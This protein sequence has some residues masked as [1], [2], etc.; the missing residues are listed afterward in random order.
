MKKY[1]A[2]GNFILRSPL[3]SREEG[4]YWESIKSDD[5]FLRKLWDDRAIIES[6]AIDSLNL[7][8]AVSNYIKTGKGSVTAIANSCRKLI[9]R[10]S[11]RTTPFGLCSGVQVSKFGDKSILCRNATNR[12]Q[13][14][15]R[16]D[17]GWLYGIITS[18]END[19]KN[20]GALQCH[21]NP[22]LASIG[23]RLVIPSF[24]YEMQRKRFD[25]NLSD[26][27]SI[28]HSTVIKHLQSQYGQKDFS[29]SEL[30][31]YLQASYPEITSDFC[32]NFIKKLIN[33]TL[34]VTELQVPSAVTDP[35]DYVICILKKRGIVRDLCFELSDIQQS[36]YE[37]N[38]LPI[39]EGL[40]TYIMC[41]EKM[42]A[43]YT[44]EGNGHYLRIDMYNLYST[45][46]VSRDV[47][48]EV[49]TFVNLMAQLNP[50]FKD[51]D[52]AAE[53]TRAFTEKYGREALVPVQELLDPDIGLGSPSDYTE[54]AGNRIRNVQLISRFLDLL[55]SKKSVMNSSQSS[56][57][58]LTEEDL[59]SF[60]GKS[61]ADKGNRSFELAFY[62]YFDN[63][64]K[65][66][67][68]VASPLI[69]STSP[70]KSVGRFT[71]LLNDETLINDWCQKE[72]QLAKDCSLD[73]VV[74]QEASSSGSVEN[75]CFSKK[76]FS[77]ELALSMN[78][79]DMVNKVNL[80][81]LYVTY[82]QEYNKLMVYSAASHKYVKFIFP[83]MLNPTLHS[84]V[85][86]L[87]QD[88]A[89]PNSTDLFFIQNL[90]YQSEYAY[91]P[92]IQFNK[93][94]LSPA[95]WRIQL[96]DFIRNEQKASFESFVEQF[97]VFVEQNAI[98]RLVTA[99]SFDRRLLLN[100]E[101]ESSLKILFGML[102]KGPIYLCEYLGCN[103]TENG[104][105]SVRP[106]Y[107]MELVFPFFGSTEQT[108]ADKAICS[109]SIQDPLAGTGLTEDVIHRA[110]KA[111]DFP[112]RKFYPGQNGWWYFKFYYNSASADRLLA[113]TLSS[114]CTTVMQNG[115]DKFFYLR[116]SDP[117]PHIR[118]RFHLTHNYL[119][120]EQLSSFLMSISQEKW[121]RDFK[122]D[123]YEREIERYG[124]SSL[125]ENAE[126][127]FYYDSL[128]ALSLLPIEDEYPEHLIQSK[129][130][131]WLFS[132]VSMFSICGFSIYDI[133]QVLGPRPK[134]EKENSYR[135]FYHSNRLDFINIATNVFDENYVFLTTKEQRVAFQNRRVSLKNYWEN[136]CEKEKQNALTNTKLDILFSLEHMFYNRYW[137]AP[138]KEEMLLRI[139]YYTV[140]DIVQRKKH[141]IT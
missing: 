18:L 26:I 17:I 59:I 93:I 56:C 115:A 21:I 80:Q 125:I 87:L 105:A 50:L 1:G 138:Q 102:K 114:F 90:G 51:N 88:I 5:E 127:F 97:N 55:L 91:L 19:H 83:N 100:L 119:S 122:I 133:E 66:Y 29:L 123:T 111:Q 4:L 137:G 89:T 84:K 82:S 131:T 81:D 141:G 117:K 10:M 132:T 78:V 52:Q 58:N 101:A 20:W 113:G 49:E 36:I 65:D 9:I 129:S 63:Q 22:D 135:K 68:L 96:K 130:K 109:S 54:Y 39:G 126:S 98:P 110:V 7:Y 37:Y 61:K 95:R 73:L 116:Y 64:M 25:E 15:A 72:E 23:N 75:L 74:V 34:I 27:S 77:K 112:F 136:I 79:N 32:I 8:E 71:Y 12:I 99:G 13:K 140:H 85:V 134:D 106:N 107:E 108:N 120:G 86:R 31:N 44:M 35:L 53:Y 76:L 33:L 103:T 104:P 69:G 94:V 118:I 40:D 16:V 57:V 11:S 28:R 121:I 41:V 46:M 60:F 48:E 14:C 139:L 42:K 43:L 92:R 124:G 128:Y 38:A 3:L 30:L 70:F 2:S 47:K 6:L 67:L 62:A 24:K 45:S